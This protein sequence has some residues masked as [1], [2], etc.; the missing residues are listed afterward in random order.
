MI[1]IVFLLLLM[2]LPSLVVLSFFEFC[3][4]PVTIFRC[5]CHL[6]TDMNDFV[7]INAVYLVISVEFFVS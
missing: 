7:Y 1:V 3:D 5:H 2:L 4:D 6:L